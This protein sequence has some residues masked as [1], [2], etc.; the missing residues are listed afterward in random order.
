MLPIQQEARSTEVYGA[1]PEH[2]G[3][4][5]ALASAPLPFSPPPNINNN[6][7]LKSSSPSPTTLKFGTYAFH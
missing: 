4:G 3:T 6:N 7:T 1:L 5:T 2:Y